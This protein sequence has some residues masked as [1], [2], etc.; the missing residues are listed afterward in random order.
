MTRFA[1]AV[2]SV[3]LLAAASGASAQGFVPPRPRAADLSGPRVGITVLSPGVVDALAERELAVR[4][5]ITQF[6][7]QLEKQFYGKDSG[8]TAVTEWVLLVGGLEQSVAVPSLSW[9]IGLRTASGTEF[10]VGP[11]LTPAGAALAFAAGVSF[12]AGPMNVPLNVAV[13]PAKA[14]TRVS[15]LTGFNLR[16]K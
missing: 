10:G 12:R 2:T 9:L 14:G 15:V 16:R 3:L 4:P 6:G 13:V 11:N 8:L 5:V 1:L 7:W